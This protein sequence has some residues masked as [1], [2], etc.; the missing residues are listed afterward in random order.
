MSQ[1]QII[2]ENG[3][4]KNVKNILEFE[5]IY[6]NLGWSLLGYKKTLNMFKEIE[7]IKKLDG[8]TAEIGV[9]E[10]KTSKFIHIL[11]PD[12]T[13]YAYDTYCGIQGSDNNIDFHKDGEFACS[14]DKV[15]E[16][17]NMDNVIY[18]VG[19]FPDTFN[20]SDQKFVFVHSDTDTYIGTKTTLEKFAPLIVSGGKIMF[21]DY[22]WYNCKGVEKAVLEFLKDNNDFTCKVYDNSYYHGNDN[23]LINQCV[24]TK[25]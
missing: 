13:H 8:N 7:E 5:S 19:F 16:N 4:E 11:F 18:K 22:Q 12:R 21:D 25:I 9:F 17:I 6:N 20:E 2:T 3:N 15:K 23:L 1:T 24:L 14:L 10:G